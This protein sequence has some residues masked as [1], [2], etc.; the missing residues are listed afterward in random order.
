MTDN[1]LYLLVNQAFAVASRP[2]HFAN[3]THCPECKEHDDLW[4]SRNLDTLEVGDINNPGWQPVCFLTP[5]GWLYYFP[6]FVRLTLENP[7]DS[8]LEQFL[9]FLPRVTDEDFS[10]FNYEQKTVVLTFLRHV[11]DNHK[12]LV[13]YEGLEGELQ[14]AIVAWEKVVER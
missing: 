9:F 7:Q 11:R 12:D 8:F 6:A 4:R 2:E 10:L 1:E 5:E 14:N 3:Y 13:E